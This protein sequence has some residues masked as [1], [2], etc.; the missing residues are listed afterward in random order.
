M[1]DQEPLS[2][3]DELLAILHESINYLHSIPEEEIEKR[4]TKINT[5]KGSGYYH[6]DEQIHMW[7][8]KFD[9]K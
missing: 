9:S 4:R 1:S 7:I 3:K 8:V 5:E 2:K 6:S